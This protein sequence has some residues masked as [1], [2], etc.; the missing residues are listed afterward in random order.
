MTRGQAWRF[1]DMG[2][3]VERALAVTRLLR[4][5]LVDASGRGDQPARR[6]AGGRPTAALTYRGRYLT[7]LEAPAVV[8]LLLADE[9]NPRSVAFQVA[10]LRDHLAAC[11]ATRPTPAGT[12]TCRRPWT[13]GR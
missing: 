4:L 7:Q 1:L 10:A 2:F 12:P 13:C 6:R 9:T 5:T 8:D 11:R 3:R